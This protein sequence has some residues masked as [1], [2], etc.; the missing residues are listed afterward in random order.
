MLYFLRT[1]K[2]WHKHHDNQEEILKIL[3][4]L[5]R[6]C[7]VDVCSVVEYTQINGPPQESLNGVLQI[8]L[9]TGARLAGHLFEKFQMLLQHGCDL[10]EQNVHGSTPF[11]HGLAVVP[12][13]ELVSVT[14]LLLKAAANPFA[15]T[16]RGE[17]C[18]HILLVRL[19]ACNKYDMRVTEAKAITD[20]LVTL[21]R[22]GCSPHLQSR[23]GYTPSDIALSPTAW[24]LWCNALRKSGIDL[25]RVL[26]QDDIDARVSYSD[27]D[28]INRIYKAALASKVQRA[29]EEPE[30]ITPLIQCLECKRGSNSWHLRPPFDYFERCVF[31]RDGEALRLHVSREKTNG[32]ANDPP[33]CIP[34]SKGTEYSWR[35]HIASRLWRDGILSSPYEAQMWATGNQEQESMILPS[36]MEDAIPTSRNASS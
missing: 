35:K 11:L 13:P 21:L 4:L 33:D 26:K 27:Y 5:I 20:L 36:D 12:D 23:G 34:P 2:G 28:E 17:G 7:D 18:L 16:A 14:S 30:S 3:R 31:A 19:S 32:T 6:Y 8:A 9:S 22:K 29:A 25:A 10:E 15:V 24:V 1:A